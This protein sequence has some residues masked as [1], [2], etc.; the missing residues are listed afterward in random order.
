MPEQFAREYGVPL[1][2]VCEALDHVT[3]NPPL[4][5]AERDR[6]ADDVRERGLDRPLRP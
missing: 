6:E 4:I 5:E 3:N 2:E 1:D